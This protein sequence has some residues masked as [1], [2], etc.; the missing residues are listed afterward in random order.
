M[1][2]QPRISLQGNDFHLLESTCISSMMTL[3]CSLEVNTYEH[4]TMSA[5]ASCNFKTFSAT[6]L[7]LAC[8][9]FTK[10]DSEAWTWQRACVR[11]EHKSLCQEL[12]LN[13]VGDVFWYPKLQTRKTS[14]ETESKYEIS[15]QIFSLVPALNIMYNW[16]DE[17][18]HKSTA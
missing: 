4:I 9:M 14:S 1:K 18:T 2:E 11:F 17:L 7:R 6:R 3:Y 12:H 15:L 8:N 16:Y 13:D 5:N 10:Q